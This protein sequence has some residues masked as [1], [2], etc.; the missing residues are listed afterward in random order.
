MDP[1]APDTALFST[2]AIAP[3]ERFAYWREAVCDVFVQLECE[4]LDHGP[5]TGAIAT[6]PFGALTLSEVAARPQHVVRS[7]RQIARAR[8]DD[9]L[10][11]VQLDGGGTI[12]QDG[13]TARLGLGDFCLYDS[14]RPYTLHFAGPFRQLVLQFPRE[15]LTERLGPAEP[16]AGMGIRRADPV[17]ALASDFLTA[18]GR[19]SARIPAAAAQ[20]LAGTGLDLLATALA[21]ARGASPEPGARR[22]A[23]LARAKML[24]LARLGDAG[25]EPA[26]VAAALGVTA[27]SLHRL[28][29][30]EGTSFM[31]WVIERRLE[32]CRRDLG[33]PAQLGRSVSDVA[34]GHGF[35]DLAHFSRAFRRRFGMAPRDF[36]AMQRAPTFLRGLQSAPRRGR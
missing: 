17:G 33:D 24:T 12:E 3:R 7:R 18:L 5:F 6:R 22:T 10:V 2:D 35:S 1:R 13:H 36:R 21:T 23:A 9:L 32:A 25:I 20:R 31:R 4:R 34:L 26:T 28:F 19:D 16:F 29:A 11:S 14:A 8:E 30:G 27:R 15:R